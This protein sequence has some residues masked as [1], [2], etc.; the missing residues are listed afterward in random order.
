[1]SRRRKKAKGKGK[2]EK[3]KGESEGR[4]TPQARREAAALTLRGPAPIMHSGRAQIMPSKP[5]NVTLALLLVGV[6]VAAV[7]VWKRLSMDT[8]DFIV[9]S[10]LPA[11][12][13]LTA[14]GVLSGLTI[15]A[16]VR[17]RQIAHRRQWLIG[18]F[19][20]EMS[21]DRRLELAFEL[22][23]LNR[24]RS[25]GLERVADTMVTLF[26]N[27][28]KT[29]LGDKQ[30][31]LRGMAASHLGVLQNPSALPLLL[32]ALEDEH[33]YVRGCAALG[34]GR[35]RAKEAAPKLKQMMEEDWDQ[36]ARSRAREA[37]E[38]LA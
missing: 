14:I 35:M 38:R 2:K 22:I 11:L 20:R 15:R 34:L 18:R 9:E 13:L 23:E 28:L 37:L 6:V 36:T 19:E 29:A 12:V 16:I 26:T 17:R 7:W 27:T 25:Q 5:V 10:A 33:A 21:T 8:Q 32:A 3:V 4:G 1:M 24:Y 31:R 30:H